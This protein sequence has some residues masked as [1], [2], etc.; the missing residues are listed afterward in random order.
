M[1]PDQDERLTSMGIGEPTCDKCMMELYA[2]GDDS[3]CNDCQLRP[4]QSEEGKKNFLKAAANREFSLP[5]E[6]SVDRF[7]KL[8]K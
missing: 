4:T 1:R 7:G 6:K 5:I 2:G 3:I 8:N